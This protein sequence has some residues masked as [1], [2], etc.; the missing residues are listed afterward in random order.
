M[1]DNLKKRVQDEYAVQQKKNAELEKPENVGGSESKAH[2]RRIGIVIFIF[3]LIFALLNVLFLVYANRIQ[4][5]AVA[6]MI[7]F[8]GLGLW[9]ML[10]GK[11]PKK[12]R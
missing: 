7:T 5:L 4:F 11:P 3:G 6:A 8:I 2:H 1:L 12:M 10:T 9:M